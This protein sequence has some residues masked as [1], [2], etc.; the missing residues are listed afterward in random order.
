MLARKFSKTFY[1]MLHS[2]HSQL[3]STFQKLLI[4]FS[5]DDYLGC[6]QYLTSTSNDILK[7]LFISPCELVG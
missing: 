3:Y 7:I 2:V 6:F 1:I 4:Y 5:N